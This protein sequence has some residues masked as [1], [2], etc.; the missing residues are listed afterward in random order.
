[1]NYKKQIYNFNTLTIVQH[2]SQHGDSETN[3]NKQSY[4]LYWKIFPQKD[5]HTFSH[6]FLK[7]LQ[8]D[9]LLHFGL[10]IFNGEADKINLPIQN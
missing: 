9:K 3:D 7:N 2:G 10:K 6:K 5:G 8:Q 4:K 1:M